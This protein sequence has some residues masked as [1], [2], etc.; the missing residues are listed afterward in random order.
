MT[1]PHQDR[2][3]RDRVIEVDAGELDDWAWLLGHLHDWLS[4][5]NKATIADYHRFDNPY[6]RFD[7][8]VVTLENFSVRAGRLAH[9]D[10]GQQ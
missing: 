1:V 3:H 7:Q 2:V 5:T 9:G 4:H 8:I 10:R 6:D